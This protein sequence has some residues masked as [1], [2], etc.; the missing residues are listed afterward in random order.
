MEEEEKQIQ[1]MSEL[2][3]EREMKDLDNYGN[4]YFEL[5]AEL[6]ERNN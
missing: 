3:I 2:E 5:E 1:D 6:E 4:R